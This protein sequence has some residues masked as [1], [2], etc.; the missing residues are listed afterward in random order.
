MQIVF[1]YEEQFEKEGKKF[2]MLRLYD[3]QGEFE[4]VF[5][6][7]LVS[8]LIKAEKLDVARKLVKGNFDVLEGLE[9]DFSEE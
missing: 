5:L 1:A 4:T 6:S 2:S 3:Q 9:L 8:L 7:K